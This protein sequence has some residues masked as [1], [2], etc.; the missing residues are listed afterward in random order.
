VDLA[1]TGIARGQ[2]QASQALHTEFTVDADGLYLD[3]VAVTLSTVHRI[4][5][6]PVSARVGTDVAVEALCHAMNGG[7][8]LCQ[9]SFVAI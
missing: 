8:K 9:V 7:L 3:H 5:P 6:T 1:M 2:V 4:Q